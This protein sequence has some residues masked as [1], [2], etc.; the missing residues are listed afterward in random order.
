MIIQNRKQG[1]YFVLTVSIAYTKSL[2]PKLW[3]L[4]DLW[5]TIHIKTCIF[6]RGLH[7]GGRHRDGSNDL[8]KAS[9]LTVHLTS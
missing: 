3:A 1:F 8:L 4:L 2:Y 6:A 7:A 9:H 5:S